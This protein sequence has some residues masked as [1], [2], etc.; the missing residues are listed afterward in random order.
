MSTNN[1]KKSS[2]SASSRPKPRPSRPAP[3][4]LAPAATAS[5]TFLTNHSHVLICLANHPDLRVRDIADTVTITERAVLKIL[6]EL[7]EAGVITRERDGRRT[8][9]EINPSIPLRHP[10]EAHR[11]V[12]HLLGMIKKQ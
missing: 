12:K 4:R 1:P 9:Y 10:V 11:S 5:W 8:R 7:E 6:S 3:P 2:L